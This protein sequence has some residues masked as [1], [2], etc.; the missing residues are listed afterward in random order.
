MIALSIL[1]ALFLIIACIGYF[2]EKSEVTFCSILGAVVTL[3]I[4]AALLSGWK[5]YIYGETI[6]DSIQVE[7]LIQKKYIWSKSLSLSYAAVVLI[8][9]NDRWVFGL[10]G[11]IANNPDII[12]LKI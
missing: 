2:D 6:E 4:I 3:L 11:S 7:E 8:K 1:T 9:G 5:I 10:D 12:Q